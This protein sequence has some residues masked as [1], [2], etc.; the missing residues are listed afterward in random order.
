MKNQLFVFVL[1]VAV[2]VLTAGIALLTML[3]KAFGLAW[4]DE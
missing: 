4:R 2:S 1:S 3:Q